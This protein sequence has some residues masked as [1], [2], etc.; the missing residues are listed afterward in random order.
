MSV[1]LG[2]KLTLLRISSRTERRSSSPIRLLMTACLYGAD[3]AYSRAYDS[4]TAGSKRPFLNRCFV[5][6]ASAAGGQGPPSNSEGE[7]SHTRFGSLLGG[8]FRLDGRLCFSLHPDRSIGR[9]QRALKNPA[10]ENLVL[11]GG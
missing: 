3:W 6:S 11:G 4:R 8:G 2:V 5:S 1:S 9:F 7:A 10:E